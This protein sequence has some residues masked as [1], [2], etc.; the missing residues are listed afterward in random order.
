MTIR[1]AE[2]KD[3]SAILEIYRPY[4]E[5][6]VV[7]FEYNVPT[8]SE[9]ERRISTVMEKY[10][11]IVAEEDGQVIGYA[12][13][14]EFRTREAYQWKCEVSVYVTNQAKGKGVGKELYDNLLYTLKQMGMVSAIA[15]MTVPNAETEGFHEKYGFAKIAEYEKVGFKN[16]GWH[17]VAFAEIQLNEYGNEPKIKWLKE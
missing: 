5:N 1:S 15:G 2:L 6:S 4:I 10:P 11:W 14:T 3:A 7:S 12:Y 13:G 16:G 9:I 8:V 17:N